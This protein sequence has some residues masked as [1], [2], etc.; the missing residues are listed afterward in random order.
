MKKLQK[1]TFIAVLVA[2]ALILYI[3]EGMIPV[4]FIAPG[5]KL[6]LSNIVTLTSLFILGFK[7]T[8]VVLIVRILLSTF[9]G[10]NLSSLMYSLSGGILSLI[11]M[12]LVKTFGKDDV[13][14]IGI[15][16]A[17]AFF[18]NVGQ[19][20][21]AAAIVHNINLVVYI[22]ILTIAGVGTG[23]LVGIT[24]NYLLKALSKIPIYKYF[25]NS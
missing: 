15:S 19:V 12:H 6:G 9:F 11:V 17:G 21:A 8:F 18:H 16:V 20:L 22:P 5:A 10:G 3:V 24:S 13:S 2:Q 4:P 14:I 23:I 1:L 7:D 25:G